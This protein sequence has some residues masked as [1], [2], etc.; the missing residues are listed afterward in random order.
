M[1]RLEELIDLL[2]QTDEIRVARPEVL[3]EARNAVYYFDELA[4][5]PIPDVL[6]ELARRLAPLGVEPPLDPAPFALGSWI[7]GDRDGNPTISPEDTRAVLALQHEHGA[8]RRQMQPGKSGCS[9][10]PRGRPCRDHP[11]P[12]ACS[13]PC[14][15]HRSSS[16]HLG[17]APS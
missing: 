2:W 10:I 6:E 16:A 15:F 7:G 14:N 5:G 11:S 8:R 13:S 4:A 17:P 3:D 9:S 12:S 1:E